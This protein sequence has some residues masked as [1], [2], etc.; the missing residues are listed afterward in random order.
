LDAFQHTLRVDAAPILTA[1][2]PDRRELKR[3]YLLTLLADCQIDRPRRPRLNPRV[4]KV[5]MS[6]G[7][8]KTADHKS[9]ERVGASIPPT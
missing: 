3:T 1:A 2:T 5:K 4:I 6:N 7:A 9:E 8:R